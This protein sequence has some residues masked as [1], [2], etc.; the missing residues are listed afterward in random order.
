MEELKK[1]RG[2]DPWHD[3]SLEPSRPPQ[4]ELLKY[5][6]NKKFSIILLNVIKIYSYKVLKNIFCNLLS[7]APA[8]DKGAVAK[9]ARGIWSK[10]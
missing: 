4:R 7:T 2:S 1:V 3:Q 10:P 6:G 5:I 8:A 9:E